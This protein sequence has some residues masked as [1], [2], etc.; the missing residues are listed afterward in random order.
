VIGELTGRT[1]ADRAQ[2]TVVPG[3]PVRLELDPPQ[4]TVA[5][6]AEQTYR[7]R[8]YDAVGASLGD[9]TRRT[10]FSIDGGRCAGA[11]CSAEQIG[12]HLV[13]GR[14]VGTDAVGTARL[15][16]QA[17]GT[18]TVA[19]LVLTPARG[20]VSVGATQVYSARGFDAAGIDRGD[21]TGRTAFAIEPDGRCDGSSCRAQHAGPHSVVGMLTGTRVRQTVPLEV[22]ETRPARL[23][24]EPAAAWV[25]VGGLQSFRITAVA[26]DGHDIG[27][28]SDRTV[29]VMDGGS[30]LRLACGAPRP[31]TYLVTAVPTGGGPV[32]RAT[33]RVTAAD[34]AAVILS[35]ASASVGQ[36]ATQAY[37]ARGLDADGNDLGDLTDRTVF[38]IAPG[39]S[40]SAAA[41]T[42]GDPGDYTVT[43]TV[44]GTPVSA[45][46]RLRVVVLAPVGDRSGAGGP[47]WVLIVG[48]AFLL[49]AAARPA[50]RRLRERLGHPPDEPPDSTQ[51]QRDGDWVRSNVRTRPVPGPVS[52]AVR[53][54]GRRA[55]LVVRL[56]AHADP[57]EPV[58]EDPS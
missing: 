19:R 20:S 31:G 40:C 34:V 8:G 18:P 50:V 41:C 53:R 39:G 29:L 11:V 57:A 28:V 14:V 46:V 58:E 3:K 37:R 33:L 10:E 27:D 13:T 38:T 56:E 4:R 48:G 26:A 2:L 47:D 30:C 36:R 22:T 1:V 23:L 43:G 24:L 42:V 9:V 45:A 6:G 55:D 15:G 49:A 44:I 5:P 54:R 21:V 17:T 35:P 16:V 52:S 25:G 32:G 7:A 51:P 12:D